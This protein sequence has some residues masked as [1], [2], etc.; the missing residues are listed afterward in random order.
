MKMSSFKKNVITKTVQP[1]SYPTTFFHLNNF[2]FCI[3]NLTPGNWGRCH[4]SCGL[5][6]FMPYAQLFEK[7]FTGAKVGCKGVGRKNSL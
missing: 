1:F 3:K 5:Y 7:L 2:N 4:K 6:P